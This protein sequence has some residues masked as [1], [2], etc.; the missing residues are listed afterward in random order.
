VLFTVTVDVTNDGKVAGDEVAQLYVSLG[1][2]N[3]AVRVLRNFER[4]SVEAGATETFSFDLTRKDL[5][6]WDT[7]A[8]DW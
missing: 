3:D 5:S 6:N 2:P 4:Q 1:G 8:Q 7:V